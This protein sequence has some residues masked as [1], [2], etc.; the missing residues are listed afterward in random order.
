MTRTVL[1]ALLLCSACSTDAQVGSMVPRGGSPPEGPIQLD[2]L[3]VIDN[4]G[5]MSEEQVSLADNFDNFI[6]ALSTLESGVPDLHIAVVS[7]NV[8]IS[9]FQTTG[10]VGDGDDGKFQNTPRG[11]CSP[12]SGYFIIDETDPVSGGHVTNYPTTATLQE[13]F[14]CIARLGSTGCGLEQH[15]ES[16]KRALDGHRPENANFLRPDAFLAVIFIADEDDCSAADGAVFDPSQISISD[17]LGPFGSFRCSEFGMLCDGAP[18]SRSPAAYTTCEPR[19]DSYLH[20][21]SHYTD[22]LNTVKADPNKIVV[23]GIVGNAAPVEVVL[24]QDANPE[25]EPS[26][27]SGNGSAIPGIRFRWFLDQFGERAAFTSICDA[28]LSVAVTDV[29]TVVRNAI[30]DY[31][32]EPDAGMPGVDP[33]GD[34]GG[35]SVGRAAGPT[36]G[37]LVLLAGVLLLAARPRRRDRRA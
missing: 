16:M 8:G 24:N 30:I 20:H 23:A 7:S 12:P 34:S 10:C 25:M 22:F 13:V 33:S 19:G 37:A 1:A 36:G 26:C 29:G 5:S 6:D 17:P 32:T 21:P 28:D 31:P 2:V 35:C 27:S 9:P 14:S 15:F 3:F 4:S 11:A 18:I